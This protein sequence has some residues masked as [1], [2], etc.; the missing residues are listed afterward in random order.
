MSAYPL[1]AHVPHQVLA[2]DQLHGQIPLV[3]D[4][5]ELH[6]LNQVAVADVRECPELPLEAEQGPGIDL[7]E[8]LQRNPL[9]TPPVKGLVYDAEG[10]LAETALDDEPVGTLDGRATPA[11]WK[12][13]RRRRGPLARGLTGSENVRLIE[14]DRKAR[15]GRSR[16]EGPGRECRWERSPLGR[17]H[18]TG[19][20][21]KS[22]QS[23]PPRV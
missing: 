3:I 12:A 22:G 21:K 2:L 11:F 23:R 19:L 5:D 7:T 16:G 18:G 14:G 20:Q 4:R 8:V 17:V 13:P 10:A 1:L 15:A 9:L 6:E